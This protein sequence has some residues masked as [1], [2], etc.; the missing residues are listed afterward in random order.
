MRMWDDVPFLHNLPVYVPELEIRW[1][2][3]RDR[4]VGVSE[5]S[6]VGAPSS[7]P[8]TLVSK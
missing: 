6:S 3:G 1:F 2:F 8:N 4:M 7:V 5:L